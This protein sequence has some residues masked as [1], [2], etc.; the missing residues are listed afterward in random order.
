MSEDTVLVAWR[1]AIK[2]GEKVRHIA[3]WDLVGEYVGASRHPEYDVEVDWLEPQGIW[4]SYIKNIYP[5]W[6]PIPDDATRIEHVK[7]VPDAV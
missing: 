4:P 1:K 7:G 2:A 6:W 3:D 5:E